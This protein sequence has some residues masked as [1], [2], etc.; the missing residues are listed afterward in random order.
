MSA[1]Q[2]TCM[3]RGLVRSFSAMALSR[4]VPSKRAV[5][6]IAKLCGRRLTRQWPFLTRVGEENLNLDF[7]DLLELQYARN[8][9][10][11]ALIVG[12]F[13]GLENDPTS[14]FIRK[15]RCGA[16]LV[17]PQPGPF[18]RLRDNMR[19]HHNIILINAAIDELS[20]FRDMYCVSAGTEELP[21]WTEQLASFQKQHILKHEDK[22]PGLSKY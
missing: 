11:I 12:A 5:A 1:P 16:I 13:D 20:G 9:N 18:K 8:R 6:A 7:N 15:R 10:F 3:I 22:A 17:E 19:E 4:R 2:L 21:S 14:E